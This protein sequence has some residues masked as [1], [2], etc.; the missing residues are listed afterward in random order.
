MLIFRFS[1]STLKCGT[2]V[3][4]RFRS[5]D[6]YHLKPYALNLFR[7]NRLK[8]EIEDFQTSFHSSFHKNCSGTLDRGD[9]KTT[10][11]HRIIKANSSVL[12]LLIGI[13]LSILFKLKLNA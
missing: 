1:F 5:F 11:W 6:F 13:T 9:C 8:N 2:R 10:F 4:K 7:E 12:S 3:N